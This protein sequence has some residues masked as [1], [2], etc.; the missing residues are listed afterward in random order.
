MVGLQ[1]V[2]VTNETL[3]QKDLALVPAAVRTADLGKY[4]RKNRKWQGIP[5]IAITECKIFYCAFYSG[6][7]GEGPDNYVVVERSAD[8]QHW[9]EPIAAVDPEGYVR[10]FDM[11]LWTAPDGRLILFWS[12]S[13][14]GFD[15]RAG[16]FMSICHNPEEERLRWS[17]SVRITDGVMLN[18][19]MIGKQGEWLLALSLWNNVPYAFDQGDLDRRIKLC[20]ADGSGKHV[21][22]ISFH[23]R[24]GFDIEGRY[25]DEPMVV[26]K[27]DGSLWMLLRLPDGIGEAFSC[28]EGRSWNNIRRAGIWGPDSRFY[29]GRLKSGRLLMVNHLPED[30]KAKRSNLTAWLSQDDGMSWSGNLILDERE[31]VSYPDAAEDKEGN[32]Y[33]IYDYSRFNCKEILLCR[34]SEEEILAGKIYRDTSFTKQVIDKA[35]E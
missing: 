17:R 24:G 10:A 21:K 34:I 35:G 12:Q 30:G 16:V 33:I 23:L 29:I 14:G 2:P 25:Y 27:I 1:Q 9:S 7:E 28:D 31:D 5:S 18:K 8:G 15:G 11:C 26:Q 20:E 22:D 3:R 13:F 19:P 4:R 32:I 6:G